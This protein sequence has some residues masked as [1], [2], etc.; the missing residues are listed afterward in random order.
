MQYSKTPDFRLCFG[1][2]ISK[3]NIHNQYEY[4]LRFNISDDDTDIPDTELER[5]NRMSW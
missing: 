2:F 5:V 3:N 1:V 4:H